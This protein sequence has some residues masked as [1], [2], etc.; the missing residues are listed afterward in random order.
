MVSA[1]GATRSTDNRR[2][3]MRQYDQAP[4]AITSVQKNATG[5]APPI[6]K[7]CESP[8]TAPAS[9]TATAHGEPSR[10]SPSDQYAFMPAR[11]A[12]VDWPAPQTI[13]KL[14]KLIQVLAT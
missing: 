6:G 7:A 11:A 14:A 3:P 1:K 12:A 9:H 10:G 8:Q 2:A 5:P 4:S 13:S